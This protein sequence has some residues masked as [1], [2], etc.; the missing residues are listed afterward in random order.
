MAAQPPE[1]LGEFEPEDRLVAASARPVAPDGVFVFDCETDPRPEAARSG[2]ILDV[3]AVASPADTPPAPLSRIESRRARKRASH[4]KRLARGTT[5]MTLS[6]AHATRGSSA[7]AWAATVRATGR[8]SGRASSSVR[9]A[10]VAMLRQIGAAMVGT[11]RFTQHM[12]GHTVSAAHAA[13]HVCARAWSSVRSAAVATRQHTSAAAAEV[14]G[15]WTQAWASARPHF[16]ARTTARTMLE[17]LEFNGTIIAMSLAMAALAYG[18]FRVGRPAPAV[19]LS[20]RAIDATIKTVPLPVAPPAA[21]L[22]VPAAETV[23]AN[24]ATRPVKAVLSATTLNAIWRRQDS[25]SLQQAFTGLRSQTLAFHRCGMRMTET[26]RAVATCEGAQRA[27][28]TINFRRSAGRW[29][30]DRVI[31]R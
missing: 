23:K 3:V 19:A 7:R 9:S 10:A 8:A 13:G 15:T 4:L 14:N 11:T 25:R 24:V 31:T 26:D 2:S 1:S 18:G 17:D 29:Q 22:A 30:I 6:V 16:G 21:V 27:K 12:G 5:R 20:A 28:W